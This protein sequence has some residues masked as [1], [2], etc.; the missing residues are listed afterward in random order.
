ML[1][2]SRAATG[3]FLWQHQ[4]SKLYRFSMLPSLARFL[5]CCIW[6]KAIGGTLT[7]RNSQRTSMKFWKPYVSR[8]K[9]TEFHLWLLILKT[10]VGGCRRSLVQKGQV[11]HVAIWMWHPTFHIFR[12]ASSSIIELCMAVVVPSVAM[13]AYISGWHVSFD[14]LGIRAAQFGRALGPVSSQGGTEQSPKWVPWIGCCQWT[15][16]NW[17][18]PNEF[19][20]ISAIHFAPLPSISASLGDH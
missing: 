8:I 15:A 3:D 10:H 7:D 17:K 16:T 4:L 9:T 5:G 18:A 2:A 6:S 14:S 12:P 20:H 11:K 1:E 19:Q 13:A